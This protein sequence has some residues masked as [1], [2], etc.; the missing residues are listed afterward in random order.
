[1]YTTDKTKNEVISEF[2]ASIANYFNDLL[3]NKFTDIMENGNSDFFFE[4]PKTISIHLKVNKT[5]SF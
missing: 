3:E 2:T 5:Y 4:D 1:M